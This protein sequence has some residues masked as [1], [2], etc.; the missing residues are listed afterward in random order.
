MWAVWRQGRLKIC[1]WKETQNAYIPFIK[2]K[3][4]YFFQDQTFVYL[5]CSHGKLKNLFLQL[6]DRAEWV[7]A[8]FVAPLDTLLVSH[9]S[10]VNRPRL[11]RSLLKVLSSWSSIRKKYL[12]FRAKK[13]SFFLKNLWILL[14]QEIFQLCTR[15]S[16]A[17]WRRYCW[18]NQHQHPKKSW[19]W[20]FGIH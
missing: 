1:N 18:L 9:K 13:V 15:K 20:S 17:R 14:F 2:Y 19:T 6:A 7:N 16:K 11:C 10:G 8:D 5:S 3:D 12:R 4:D